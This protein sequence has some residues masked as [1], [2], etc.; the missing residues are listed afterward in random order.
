M[1]KGEGARVVAGGQGRR[2]G[3]G[4]GGFSSRSPGGEESKGRIVCVCVWM[5][6]VLFSSE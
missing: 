1:D 5:D 6:P 2:R 3:A 4:A